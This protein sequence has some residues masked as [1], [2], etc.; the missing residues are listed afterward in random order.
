MQIWLDQESSGR[1]V[2]SWTISRERAWGLIVETLSNTDLPFPSLSFFLSPFIL[3]MGES[4]YP[5][6]LLNVNANV[7]RKVVEWCEH[8]REDPETLPD[9]I[10]DTRRKTMVISDWDERYMQVD[11]EMLF[12]IILAANYLEIKPLL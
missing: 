8:H 3:G 5:I 1:L 9:D 12:E 7:M 11:D 4:Y 2:P 6:P 10:E